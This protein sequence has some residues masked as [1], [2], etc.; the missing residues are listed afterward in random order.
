MTSR[1]FSLH[2]NDIPS[3]PKHYS[4]TKTKAYRCYAVIEGRLMRK[5]LSCFCS[6][7]FEGKD[8]CHQN[9][10]GMWETFTLPSVKKS[11]KNSSPVESEDEEQYF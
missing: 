8:C 7:H 10:T 4:I 5:H 1:K 6:K 11:S 9:I 3:A 2:E